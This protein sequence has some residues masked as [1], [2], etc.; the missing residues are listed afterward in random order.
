MAIFLANLVK[1]IED[2]NTSFYLW[3][4]S[5]LGIIALRVLMENWLGGMINR[6]GDYFFHHVSYTFVFFLLSYL[7]FLVLIIKNLKIEIKKASNVLLWGYLIIIFPPLIDFILL[8]DRAY[9]SFYGI[10]GLAEMPKRFVTFFGDSPDFGITYGVRFEIAV[11]VLALLVYGYLKTKSPVKALSLALQSYV[12]LFI[13]GTFPSWV[14]IISQGF[15]KG[16]MQIGDLEI[17]KLFFTSARLFSRETGTYLNALSIKLSLIYATMLAGLIIGGLFLSY[18]DK[19]VVFLKNSRPVQ[20]IYHLG[21]LLLG[22]VLGIIFTKFNWDF[23]IFNFF[24]FLNIS[25]AVILAWLASVVFND[26][27]DERIDLVTN[28]RRPLAVKDFSQTEYVTIGVVLFV[29]SIFYATLVNPKV[30][31]LLIAYQLLAWV[32]SAWPFRLK[33][34]PLVATLISALASLLIIFSGFILVSPAEDILEFPKR[35]FWLVL[36]ALI[37]SLPIKDLKDIKGDKLDKVNTIPVIFGEYWGKIIIGSGIFMSYFLS[38]VFLNEYALTFWAIVVGGASF[39]V[40]VFSGRNKRINNYNLIWWIL[41]LV[42]IY[43]LIMIKIIFL[44]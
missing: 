13:L 25:I 8:R 26:I 11:T 17:V 42:V 2:S 31:F 35:I 18:R 37:F 16:F 44:R 29:F 39:G 33:R 15:S 30:A 5:F 28:P 24:G 23:N 43:L 38:V 34:F 7:I 9:L 3:V 4:F 20:I 19:F 40:V 6:T 22:G 32:Y 27:Y 10:Y 12:I 41:G 36:I 1:R 21:L 14:T